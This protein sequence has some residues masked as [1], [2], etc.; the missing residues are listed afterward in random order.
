MPHPASRR[1]LLGASLALL[2]AASTPAHGQRGRGG[3][4]I[5]LAHD[6]GR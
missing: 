3:Q 1:A 6:R 5:K 4:P 2:G